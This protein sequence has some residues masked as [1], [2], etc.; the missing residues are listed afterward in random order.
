MD[1]LT[2][3]GLFIA[4]TA[5][6]T[7]FY[8][9]G[10]DVSMLINGSAML[11]VLGGSFGAILVQSMASHAH[12][13]VGM[14]HWILRAPTLDFEDS[15]NRMTSWAHTARVDG[16]LSLEDAALSETDPLLQRGLQLLVD[17]ADASVLQQVLDSELSLHKERQKKAAHVFEA[18]GG[19]CPT[20]GMLGSVLGLVL[21]MDNISNP[22]I[23]ARGI[24]SA[25]ITTI[26]G[27]GLAN[28]V[29]L[30]IANKL[31][32][33]IDREAIY[34]SMLIEGLCSIA[35]GE[36]PRNIELKLRAYRS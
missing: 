11:I 33:L 9:D 7:S 5:I 35:A 10:G 26:Y 28:M 15:I 17:G 4:V 6:A 24:A 18:I 25:F 2:I 16:F 32:A 30:P 27:V 19:Y 23:L 3:I 22:E 14:L 20:F 31:S 36:N 21:A 8:M 34:H 29:F 12:R 1:K 13:A